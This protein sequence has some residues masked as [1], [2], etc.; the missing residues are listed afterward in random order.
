MDRYFIYF[1]IVGDG[2]G[3]YKLITMITTCFGDSSIPYL[4]SEQIHWKMT[5]RLPLVMSRSLVVD[6][7]C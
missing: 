5:L 4:A 3:R 7:V 6:G 2:D 1:H